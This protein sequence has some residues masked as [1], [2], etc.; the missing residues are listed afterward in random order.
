[1]AGKVFKRTVKADKIWFGVELDDGT[2][3][4]FDCRDA[5]PGGVVLGVADLAGGGDA[6]ATQG[7]QGAAA[8]G[9]IRKLF[10]AAIVKP[11][12][13]MFWAMVEGDDD[14]GMID[15]SQMMDIAFALAEVYTERPTGESS[16]GGSPRTGDGSN[17]TVGAQPEV[18]T[19]AR[20]PQFAPS[21]SSSTGAKSV[22]P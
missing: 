16:E 15:V 11:Q 7:Q 20:S 3:R 22:A 17:S 14:A 18:S 8:I 9:V 12:R 4:R 19:Y 21:I 2:T 13:A 10:Q 1:M 6:A 5:I